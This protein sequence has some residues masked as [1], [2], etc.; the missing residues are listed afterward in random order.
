MVAEMGPEHWAQHVRQPVLFTQVIERLA[1]DGCTLFLEISPHPLLTGAIQQTLRASGV[2]GLALSSCRRGD[3]ERGSLLNSLGTLYTLGWPVNWPAVTGGG[4]DDL[5]L[6]IPA[7][8]QPGDIAGGVVGRNSPYCFLFP[9]RRPKPSEIAR[10]PLHIT[11]EQIKTWPLSDIAYVAA[12]RRE[13][14]EHRLAVVG[15]RREELFSAL[16]AFAKN[17]NPV[18][19]LA[20]TCRSTDRPKVA[21]VCSGQ[22]PQWWGMGRE[23]LASMPIFRREIARCADADEAAC[24]LGLVEELT[25]DEANSRLH[26]TEIA[27]PALFALQ[28][29][30]AAVWRSWGIEPH[31]LVGHSV[32]EVAAAHLG[33]V[34]SFDDAVKVICHRGR[35]MQMEPLG[36]AM[37][38]ELSGLAPQTASIP[39]YST[40]TGEEAKEED[41]DT[42]YWERN[43]REPVRFAAAVRAMLDA[44]FHTFVELSPHPVLSSMVLQCAATLSRKAQVLPSLRQ[45]NSDRSRMLKTLAALFVAGAEIDW[46]RVFAE[47]GRVVPLPLY[48]WQRKRYWLA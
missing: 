41:F 17:Q 14:L 22:G 12:T 18:N 30:L 20:A 21:F 39:I 38:K 29:A 47:G 5:S 27:Q 16:E 13:H 31:A 1:H 40:V 44:G 15:T 6:P 35:L 42:V 10:D 48:P 23:L 46:Q 3:D 32:G 28:V 7:A 19:L 2:D 26:E 9:A 37:A 4:H 11:Y 36:I 33:G 8:P 43:I 45:G 34:L 24:R 25:R